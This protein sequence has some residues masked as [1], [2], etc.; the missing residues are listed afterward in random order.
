M[1]Q[2]LTCTRRI[3]KAL[4]E[5]LASME[6]YNTLKTEKKTMIKRSNYWVS[7]IS[8]IVRTVQKNSYVGAHLGY[9]KNRWGSDRH[10]LHP[11]NF[12]M[13]V[14]HPIFMWTS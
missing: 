9:G 12:W 13:L 6:F 7:R 5:S 1:R 2:K 14:V 4:F 11:P 3:C 8:I 10:I